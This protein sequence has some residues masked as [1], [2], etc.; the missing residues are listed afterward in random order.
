MMRGTAE[1]DPS[2]VDGMSKMHE[3]SSVRVARWNRTKD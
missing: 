3:V 1:P 2:Q